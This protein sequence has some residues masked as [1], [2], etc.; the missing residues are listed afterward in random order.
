MITKRC[1]SCERTLE[2]DDDQAGAKVACPHCGDI[3]R[4]PEPDRAAIA[5]L[6]PDSGPERDVLVLRPGM[7]RAHPFLA[8]FTLGIG[9][10][11]L[12]L[13]HLG[14]RVQITNKRTIYRRGLL[15]KST[16]EVMHDHVRNIQIEQSFLN[17]LFNVGKIGISSSGQS[18]IEIEVHSVPKPHEVKRIIDH[19]R[20]M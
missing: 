16:T 11:I 8:I 3:N 18:A 5:G 14:D 12:W 17:R 6:P 4:V 15:S 19:Y 7:S 10:F 13:K 2:F 1:D 9:V 20:P